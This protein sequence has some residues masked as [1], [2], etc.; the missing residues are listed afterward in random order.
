MSRTCSRTTRLAQILAG[1]GQRFQPRGELTPSLEDVVAVDDDVADIDADAELDA[2]V[3][4]HVDGAFR[5]ADLDL[6]GAAHRVDD[7]GELH[8]HAV[9]G[10]RRSAR[11]L[12]PASGEGASA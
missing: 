11:D 3:G 7:A 4:R 1:L 8:Q 5:H 6:G 9:A 10:R 12:R 2:A